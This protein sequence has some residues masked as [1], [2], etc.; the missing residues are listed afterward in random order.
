MNTTSSSTFNGHSINCHPEG[1]C[2]VELLEKYDKAI[3]DNL[4]KHSKVL[5]VRFDLRYPDDG[6]I[7]PTPQHMYT[8]SDYLKRDLKRNTPLD[9]AGK[10]RRLP[11]RQHDP[12]PTLICVREKHENKERHHIHGIVLVNGH[13]KKSGYDVQKRVERQ[14]KNALGV[15]Q[16]EGLVDFCNRK[17]PAA[18][19]IDKSSPTF[20]ADMD[21]AYYSGSYICK[22]RGKEERDKGSWAMTCSRGQHDSGK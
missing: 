22:T 10:R 5:Q 15:E 4:K 2:Y 14:W 13:A 21:A 20:E 17:G 9:M 7:P 6:S 19:M 11:A 12:D 3:Q 8:F 16:V 18:I 1:E